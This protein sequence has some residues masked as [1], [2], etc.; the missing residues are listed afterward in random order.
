M[1]NSILVGKPQ[2]KVQ[3]GGD[4]RELEDNMKMVLG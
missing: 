4:I 2:R 1:L 3:L